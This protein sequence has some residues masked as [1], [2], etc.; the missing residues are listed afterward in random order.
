MFRDNRV[1]EFPRQFPLQIGAD[2]CIGMTGI[3]VPTC[4]QKVAID[5]IRGEIAAFLA[6]AELGRPDASFFNLTGLPVKCELAGDGI[7]VFVSCCECGDPF[8]PASVR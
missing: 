6:C 2:R 7:E 8:I 5:P 3:A 4:R 1:R